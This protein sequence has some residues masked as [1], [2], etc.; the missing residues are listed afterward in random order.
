MP[1]INGTELTL[2]IANN[3]ASQTA[4]TWIAIA[5]SKS[6]SLSISADLPDA[7]NKDSSG[8]SEVIA[9]QKSWTMDFEAL[10]DLSLASSVYPADQTNM[11]LLPLWT[12]FSQR[13]KIKVAWGK[14]DS[15]WYGDAFISSLE[16]SAEAEQPVSFSGSLTGTGALV[17]GNVG[18]TGIPTYSG[19]FA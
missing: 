14:D 8:W 10:L 18:A 3:D 5:L 19:S 13:S 1:A 11:N 6:A 4:T 16:E 15:Y 9:G 7:S 2:Y 17:Y 12:Y